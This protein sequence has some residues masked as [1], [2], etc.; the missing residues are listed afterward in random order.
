V[1]K[2]KVIP[3][4]RPSVLIVQEGNVTVKCTLV[5]AVRPIGRVE[6]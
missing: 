2:P 6:V 5:Q 4:Q 1:V 3:F